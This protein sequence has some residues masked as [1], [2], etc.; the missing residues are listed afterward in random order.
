MSSRKSTLPET[1]L[2]SLRIS[3]NSTAHKSRTRKANEL[4]QELYGKTPLKIL[5]NLGKLTDDDFVKIDSDEMELADE[6]EEA[7]LPELQEEIANI[8]Q[9]IVQVKQFEE[10]KLQK[11]IQNKKREVKEV[12]KR[13]TNNGQVKYTFGPKSEVGISRQIIQDLELKLEELQR[14]TIDISLPIVVPKSKVGILKQKAKDLELKLE[15]ET[16]E[17]FLRRMGKGK[18]KRKK[19]HKKSKKKHKKKHTKKHRKKHAK[20]HTKK[21]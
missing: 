12:E 18:R 11:E 9:E 1:E 7:K 4:A 8:K 14:E 3:E 17:I 2:Q 15:R 5:E 21:K 20:K 19:T 16:T 10:A 6:F 13:Y